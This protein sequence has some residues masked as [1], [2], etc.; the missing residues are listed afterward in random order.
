VTLRLLPLLLLFT[1]CSNNAPPADLEKLSRPKQILELRAAAL[2]SGAKEVWQK[3]GDVAMEEGDAQ[4]AL[5]AYRKSGDAAQEKSVKAWMDPALFPPAP[6]GAPADL[7]A[8]AVSVPLAI[9]S[10]F[11]VRANVIGKLNQAGRLFFEAGDR[12]SAGECVTRAQPLVAA[13]MKI[14]HPSL[15]AFHLASDHDDLY[16]DM[17]FANRH[18]GDAREFYQNS[19]I[20]FKNWDPPNDYTRK[21]LQQAKNKV[22]AC[23]KKMFP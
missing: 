13:I 14:T 9:D 20:R 2:K 6:T 18:W 4:A 11:A 8:S 23:E 16:G 15:Y 17:L 3:L 12:K 21:R 19:V 1:G 7:Y 10:T 5:E 22:L